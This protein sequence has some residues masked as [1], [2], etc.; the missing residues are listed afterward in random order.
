MSRKLSMKCIDQNDVN[1]FNDLVKNGFRV[2]R[3]IT[4]P[5]ENKKLKRISSNITYNGTYLHFCVQSSQYRT[6]YPMKSRLS[7]K[8]IKYLIRLGVDERLPDS[9]GLTPMDILKKPG[10]IDSYCDSDD[11]SDDDSDSDEKTIYELSVSLL[12][13]WERRVYFLM[14]VNRINKTNET[15]F[16]NKFDDNIIATIVKFL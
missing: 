7:P 8:M 3:L 16:I 4:D 12:T 13:Q 14:S 6:S 9:D 5:R 11:D 2:P 10:C 15:S 1:G